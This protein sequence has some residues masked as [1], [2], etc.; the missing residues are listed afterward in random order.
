MLE[1]NQCLHKWSQLAQ[2]VSLSTYLEAAPHYQSYHPSQ[3]HFQCPEANLQ[4]Q[5]HH[6]P[7]PLHGRH[8]AVQ[9]Y[10][11][12]QRSAQGAP[13]DAAEHTCRGEPDR[14]GEVESQRGRAEVLRALSAVIL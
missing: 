10:T 8:L 13:A 6:H 4:K 3:H 2:K 5:P 12:T 9:R 11:L 14:E 7:L 1:L